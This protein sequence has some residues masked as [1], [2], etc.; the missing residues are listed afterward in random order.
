M[1]VEP[2][3]DIRHHRVMSGL[4]ENVMSIMGGLREI[5]ARRQRALTEI[6]PCTRPAHRRKG[7]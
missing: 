7:H 4:V 6:H 1:V 3:D 5:A 2:A